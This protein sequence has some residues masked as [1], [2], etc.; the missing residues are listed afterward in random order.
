MPIPIFPNGVLQNKTQFI[1]SEKECVGTRFTS[2]RKAYEKNEW[3]IYICIRDLIV[4]GCTNDISDEIMLNGKIPF[5][6]I[7]SS[8]AFIR[9]ILS[10]NSCV[11][12]LG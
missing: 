9:K 12:N 8:R 4:R 5:S 6:I 3:L 2:S 10:F 11:N 1:N 7:S